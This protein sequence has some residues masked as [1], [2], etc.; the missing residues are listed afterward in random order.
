MPFTL[1]QLI[2]GLAL[3]TTTPYA[4]PTAN[5]TE[6]RSQDVL[7]CLTTNHVP[8]AVSTSTNWASLVTP[9]NLR[10]FY[11]PAVITLPTTPQQVSHSVTCAAAAGL[12]V[13]AKS[14]GHSYASYS[15]GGQN[16]SLIVSLQ[17]FHSISVDNCEHTI[18]IISPFTN[19][20]A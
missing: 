15:S 3:F 5:D 20:Y 2:A 4:I 18:Q 9:Y 6:S 10:L 11:E 1:L 13:Q 14:G 12:K 16:G 7:S 17:A 8:F 19:K